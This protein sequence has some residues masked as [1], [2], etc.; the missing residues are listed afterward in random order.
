VGSEEIAAAARRAVA[1]LA[2]RRFIVLSFRHGA[3]PKSK[4]AQLLLKSLRPDITT[5]AVS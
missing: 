3:S 5:A 1:K 4:T 2:V